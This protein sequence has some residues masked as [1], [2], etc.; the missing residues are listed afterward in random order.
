M[1]FF[2]QTRKGKKNSV[3]YEIHKQLEGDN[4]E[5]VKKQLQRWWNKGF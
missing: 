1:K 4:H 2:I 5:K 3:I